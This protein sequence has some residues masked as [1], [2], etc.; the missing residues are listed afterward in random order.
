MMNMSSF[1]FK[2]VPFLFSLFI[3]TR[4]VCALEDSL[5]SRTLSQSIYGLQESAQR[6][7]QGNDQL[8]AYVNEMSMKV[9]A[10]QARLN[11]LAQ[12]NDAL[13]QRSLMLSAENPVLTKKIT[14]LENEAFEKESQTEAVLD[15][16]ANQRT[17]IERLKGQSIRLDEQLA[18]L[19]AN[20]AIAPEAVVPLSKEKMRLLK[21]IDESKER[22]AKLYDQIATIQGRTIVHISSQA[23]EQKAMNT[24]KQLEE[25]IGQ[26][27]SLRQTNA[28]VAQKD[29]MQYK[30]LMS[31]VDLLQKNHDELEKLLARLQKDF[32]SEQQKRSM[33]VDDLRLRNNQEAIQK[34]IVILKSQ[35]MDLRVQMVELDKRKAYLDALS[36]GGR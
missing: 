30:L 31:Q 17:E 24:V 16:M 36:R 22:Q 9:G 25:E 35:V 26:M 32:K 11:Q 20:V 21:L 13:N 7:I 23:E 8:S 18:Q 15:Q 28:N 4:P 1:L 27:Q 19:Q 34:E 12:E 3:L 5:S 14:A 2:A 10:L 6:L 29:D 33:T